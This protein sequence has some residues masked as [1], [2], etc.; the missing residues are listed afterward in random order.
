MCTYI[1]T[2][3]ILP[4]LTIELWFLENPNLPDV[5][6]VKRVDVVT[7][8]LN[9]PANA[10]W[11]SKRKIEEVKSPKSFHLSLQVVSILYRRF[12]THTHSHT[13]THHS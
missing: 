4:K 6:V 5:H 10:V 2:H 7:P 3:V 12:N 11:N 13:P 8:L 9:L 1:Y